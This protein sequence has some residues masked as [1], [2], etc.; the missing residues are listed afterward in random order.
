MMM[1]AN[2]G[3]RLWLTSD[4]FNH[5]PENIPYANTGTCKTCGR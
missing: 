2:P 1:K 4:G 3:F 5:L